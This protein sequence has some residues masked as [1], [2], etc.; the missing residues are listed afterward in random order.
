MSIKRKRD[1]K[2]SE[3]LEE[4]MEL[5]AGE[6]SDDS[7]DIAEELGAKAKAAIVDPKMDQDSL[8]A[9]WALFKKGQSKGK[10]AKEEI[11]RLKGVL[12]ELDK[13]ADKLRKEIVDACKGR[14]EAQEKL[15]RLKSLARF[16]DHYFDDFKAVH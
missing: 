13:E 9:S 7:K 1:A 14:D 10:K 15:R 11:S 2:P 6:L 5:E 4:L 16:V 8:Q 3:I 12:K